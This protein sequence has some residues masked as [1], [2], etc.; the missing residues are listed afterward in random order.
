MKTTALML[1]L[2]AAVLLPNVAAAAM[3]DA[4]CT[5]AFVSADANKDG[6]LSDTEGRRYYA[7]LR[8]AQRPVTDGKLT[9]ADFLTHCKS[10]VFK[11]STADAGAPL[12]GSNS[13]TEAQAQDRAMAA[14]FGTISALKKDDNGVWRGTAMDGSKSVNVAVDYKGNVVTN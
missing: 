11:A 3:T 14:G 10:D 9:Q 4:E 7:S 1:G 13:F 2:G 8:V 5:A 12:K 6:I